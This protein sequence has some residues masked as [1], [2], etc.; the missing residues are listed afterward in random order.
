MSR[1]ETGFSCVLVG[2]GMVGET[3]PGLGGVDVRIAATGDGDRLTGTAVAVA[4]AVG[5][6]RVGVGPI[7]DDV[8][9]GVG[10]QAG[11]RR[12]DVGVAAGA[13]AQTQAATKHTR[14]AMPMNR[15][16]QVT[17]AALMG[18][19]SAHQMVS[20][21]GGWRGTRDILTQVDTTFPT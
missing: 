2:N 3:D 6:R 21:H 20:R 11:G 8:P 13:Q 5:G 1:P 4:V 14:L 7:A 17:L 16:D 10:V 12:V 18:S 9:A 19:P 15:V